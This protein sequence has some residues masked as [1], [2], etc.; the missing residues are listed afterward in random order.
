LPCTSDRNPQCYAQSPFRA[1]LTVDPPSVA[2]KRR[3]SHLSFAKRGG[4]REIFSPLHLYNHISTLIKT[5]TCSLPPALRHARSTPRAIRGAARGDA[6]QSGLRS[7]VSERRREAREASADNM[8][9]SYPS[10]W[11][12]IFADV[13]LFC[14][15]LYPVTFP[16]LHPVGEAGSVQSN[17]E[18]YSNR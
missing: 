4:A 15:A 7:C 9:N 12:G 10:E 2:E 18:C 1:R 16:H 13:T 8:A 17:T 5:S 11:G 6:S 14:K 3:I